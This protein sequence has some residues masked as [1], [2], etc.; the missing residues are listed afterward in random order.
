MAGSSSRVGTQAT[1]AGVVRDSSGAVLPGVTVEVSSSALIEKSRN[2]VT[3][4]TGQ[5]KLTELL[6]GTY[7][8][9]FTLGGFATVK[10][11]NVDIS[12]AGVITINAD[13]KVGSVSETITVTGETPVVDVQ[14]ARR[15]EVLGNDVLK[16]LPV[17]R[18]Y[19]ALLTAV[20]A[21]TGGSLD[22]A[23]SPTMRIFTSH[24]GRGNEGNMS[25]DGLNVGAAFNGGGVS[26]YI[27]DTSNSQEMQMTLS[28]G[29]GETEMGGA[30][31]NFV[32]K[33]GGN[34]FSGGSSQAPRIVVA[35]QSRLHPA[36][37]RNSESADDSQ[38]L[39]HQRFARRPIK[40]T[41]CGSMPRSGKLG[42]AQD[43]PGAYANA[44]AG[45]PNAWTYVANPAITNR[46]AS[47]QNI[48]NGRVTW[49]ASQRNKFSFYEDYQGNC[50]QASY[51]ASSGA[52]RDAG[53]NWLATGSFGAF[54]S[55]ES[56]TTY[57]PEPQNVAQASWTPTVTSKL[58]LEAGFSSYV[59]RW[60][61]MNPPGSL[62]N[63][64]QVTQLAPFMQFRGLDDYFNNFQSPNVWRASASYVTGAHS[65][66]G[67][68]SGRTDREDRGLCERHEPDLS[69]LRAE[70]ADRASPCASRRGRSATGPSTRRSMPR[71]S[72]RWVA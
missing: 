47:S 32:P 62:T 42:Q 45:D 40:K 4:G 29:L 61:W 17:T 30:T 28:G 21:V 34:T 44:N 64:T 15:Q 59:S 11:E 71:I 31:V 56:F 16:T 20:P 57:N 9:T 68:L 36:G 6:P 19:D 54:Q 18:S 60:G 25:L 3:D 48:Y 70:S 52:C 5:Y 67:R 46:N 43:I 65:P 33:T 22:V 37:V 72:G 14:S 69:L 1:L 35:G 66:E 53:S 10:R 63:M 27:V 26:G 23:L 51:L 39:R 12:G 49:Q 7:T 2:A 13:M 24:G 50:S 8:L 55:P 38:Q 41:S 58:L